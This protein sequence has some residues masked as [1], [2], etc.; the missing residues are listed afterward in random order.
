MGDDMEWKLH[1]M[2]RRLAGEG[3]M[4]EAVTTL[5]EM[6]QRAA[7]RRIEMDPDAAVRIVE[8]LGTEDEDLTI[9][10]GDY[11]LSSRRGRPPIGGGRG[12][13]VRIDFQL[14]SEL[15]GRM[16]DEALRLGCTKS[17][18]YRLAVS[19]FVRGL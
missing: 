2:T 4:A 9:H 3:N 12:C 8:A 10:E 19:S 18:L 13:S 7:G 11:T 5:L 6:D 14:D 16:G 17:D 15:A 1:P